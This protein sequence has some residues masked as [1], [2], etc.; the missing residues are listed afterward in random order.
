MDRRSLLVLIPGALGASLAAGCKEKEP[1]SCVDASTLAPTEAKVRT[2]LNYQDRS[3][4]PEKVC[5]Q[6]VQ[7]LEPPEAGSCGSCKIMKG[8]VHPRGTCNVF[9]RRV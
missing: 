4:D 3:P 2:T 1:D 9:T 8:P 5:S 6:C 7:Y